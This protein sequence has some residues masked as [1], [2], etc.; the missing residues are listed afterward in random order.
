[1]RAPTLSALN[2]PALTAQQ[3]E[4]V[5]ARGN[6][7]VVA[8]AGAGKT[9]TLVERCMAWLLDEQNQGSV[10][11]ILMVTFTQAAAAEMRKRLR[12]GLE[13]APSSSARLAEQ[14]ALLE[15]A[16]ICTLHRFCFELVSQHFYELGLDPQLTVMSNEESHALARR[17]LDGV[18]EAVYNSDLPAD[19]AIQRLIQG[20]GGDWDQPV[21]DLADLAHGGVEKLA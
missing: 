12:E 20:T 19:L 18:L 8:G 11:E 13:R 5:A 14:L 9:R 21:R 17:T 10:D 2:L 16:H 1:M 6:V 3:Q 15:T 7:L 4:A